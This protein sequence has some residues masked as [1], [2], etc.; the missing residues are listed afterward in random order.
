M[1]RVRR[2]LQQTGAA[3]PVPGRDH[4]DRQGED[5]GLCAEILDHADVPEDSSFVDLGGDSLSYV[6]MSLRLEESLGRLPTDW[7]RRTIRELR[8]MAAPASQRMGRAGG[9]A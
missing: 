1:S 3:A 9:A 8:A 5:R 4:P 6:E 7:H 2:L